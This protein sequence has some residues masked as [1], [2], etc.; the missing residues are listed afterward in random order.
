MKGKVVNELNTRF[1]PQEVLL[2]TQRLP[3]ESL[4]TPQTKQ[5]VLERM[6]ALMELSD[7]D[8]LI[9]AQKRIAINTIEVH[10]PW[11]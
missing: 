8:D 2:M 7:K 5:I 1:M 3:L 10:Q 11:M 4:A 6:K 9:D